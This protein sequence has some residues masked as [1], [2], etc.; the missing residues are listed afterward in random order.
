MEKRAAKQIR[1]CSEVRPYVR[2]Y[3]KFKILKNESD[4]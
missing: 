2:W 3:I 4:L 1:V